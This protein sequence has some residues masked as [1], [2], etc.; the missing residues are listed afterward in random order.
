[1]PMGST[2][3]SL[4]QAFSTEESSLSRLLNSRPVPMWP[5][6]PASVTAD[7]RGAV[8]KPPTG[9]LIMSGLLVHG[10]RSCTSTRDTDGRGTSLAEAKVQGVDVGE[11]DLISHGI[12]VASELTICEPTLVSSDPRKPSSG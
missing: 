4:P 7:A 12:M 10:R 9:A 1:M 2:P 11:R 8:A 5:S 3:S 6:P